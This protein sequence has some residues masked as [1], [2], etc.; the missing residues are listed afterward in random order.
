MQ[1]CK[2]TGPNGYF[3]KVW[4]EAPNETLSNVN[5]VTYYLHPTFNPSVIS[6]DSPANKFGISFTGWG[7]FDLRAKVYF[8][9]GEVRD[10]E[11]SKDKW[12]F[13]Q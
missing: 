2:K 5:N 6:G 10:L 3:A 11:L 8:K 7:V 13:T 1:D 9:D 12:T 4:V